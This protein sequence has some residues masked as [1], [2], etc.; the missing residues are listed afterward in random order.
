MQYE[1]EP[2]GRQLLAAAALAKTNL[3]EAASVLAANY[4]QLDEISRLQFLNMGN[5]AVPALRDIWKTEHDKKSLTAAA[6][7]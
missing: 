7:L 2:G 6:G 3:P 1:Q 5:I 4:G